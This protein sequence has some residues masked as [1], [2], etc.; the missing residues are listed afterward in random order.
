MKFDVKGRRGGLRNMYNENSLFLY[1]LY[2]FFWE[3]KRRAGDVSV[4][5]Q[6]KY[7][8]TTGTHRATVNTKASGHGT[9]PRRR[10]VTILLLDIHQVFAVQHLVIVIAPDVSNEHND[11]FFSVKTKGTTAYPNVGK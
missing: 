10:I 3:G 7:E 1:P 8:V 4:M 9:A 6:S 5:R 11:I 2:I